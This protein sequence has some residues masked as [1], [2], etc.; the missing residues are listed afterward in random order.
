MKWLVSLLLLVAC[1]ASAQST[2]PCMD[3]HT[4]KRIRD[5]M[6]AAVDNAL[7]E[8][9]EHLFS[10]WARDTAEQPKRAST[11]VRVAVNAYVRARRDLDNWHPPRCP[12]QNR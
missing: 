9:V 8:Y 6:S 10:N 7:K 5:I 2:F 11:G 1:E 12:D 4:E 3:D